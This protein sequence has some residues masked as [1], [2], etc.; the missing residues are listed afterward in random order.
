MVQN[1]GNAVLLKGRRLFSYFNASFAIASLLSRLL[2][3]T[4]VI[5]PTVIPAITM[6]M[7]TKARMCRIIVNL[8]NYSFVFCEIFYFLGEV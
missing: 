7:Q 6:L 3:L 5:I 2:D 4:L 8:L 1:K